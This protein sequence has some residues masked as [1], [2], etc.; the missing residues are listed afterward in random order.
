MPR[1]AAVALLLCLLA[2]TL[3][4]A[5][6]LLI[7]P[8]GL[9]WPA[10]PAILALRA[11]RAAAGLIV[12]AALAG[13]GVMLQSL[14]RNPLAAPEL[15]GLASGAGLTVSLAAYLGY[16]A[17]EGVAPAASPFAAAL[18]GSLGTL[19]LVYALG[20]KRGLI[21][22][23]ALILGG[24]ED[25]PEDHA[26]QDQG[27]G[28]ILGAATAL[29]RSLMPPDESQSITIWLFGTL[30]DE[31][32]RSRL[33]GAGIVTL[34]GVA[35]AAW[36]GRAMDAMAMSADEALSV[37]VR[38]GRV[39]A[40]LFI[41]SGVLTAA[42][43]SI[44]GP[45]GFVGFVCP[46]VARLMMGPAHRP[47]AIGAAAL[48]AALVIGADTLV[49]AIDLPSGRLPVGVVTALLGGPVLIAMLRG[50]GLGRF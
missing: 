32:P 33:W 40:M 31:L 46:H 36:L 20:Q 13:A 42:A 15:L 14:F 37:G 26:D 24:A 21:E 41:A 7:D 38:V 6:R 29:V 49:R 16:R 43:V 17:G 5:A 23:V 28:V 4:V 39:R 22:P 1:R 50:R 27:H 25:H 30:S 18:I 11:D 12:G 45:I 35:L 10:D 9:A 34:L 2:L 8:A 3:A 48:G 47:L 44:A 19:A